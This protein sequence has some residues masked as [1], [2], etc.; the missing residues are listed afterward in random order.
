MR[1]LREEI[2]GP[3]FSVF[4][5]SLDKGLDASVDLGLGGAGVVTS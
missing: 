5:Y 2:F 4:A 3:V 1:A